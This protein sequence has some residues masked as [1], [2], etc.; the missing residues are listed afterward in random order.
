MAVINAERP[1]RGTS[2]PLAADHT[3]RCS[4]QCPLG[5]GGPQNVGLSEVSVQARFIAFMA[6]VTSGRAEKTVRD[7]QIRL[8]RRQGLTQSEIACVVGL[9]RPRVNQIL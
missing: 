6:T 9:S 4:P 8:L 2:P 1:D 7:E 3:V 5:V